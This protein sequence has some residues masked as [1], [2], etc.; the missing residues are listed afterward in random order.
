MQIDLYFLV[1]T[2]VGVFLVV[3][4]VEAGVDEIWGGGLATL[5]VSAPRAAQRP[6]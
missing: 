2:L 5:G 1:M 3:F 6:S 4:G